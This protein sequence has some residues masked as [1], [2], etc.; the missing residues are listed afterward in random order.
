ML[1][2]R[3]GSH[4][5]WAG[6]NEGGAQAGH[7][8]AMVVRCVWVEPFCLPRCYRA[9][10]E[11]GKRLARKAAQ[12]PFFRDLL[13]PVSGG[14][15]IAPPRPG[16]QSSL[17][18]RPPGLQASRGRHRRRRGAREA[19]QEDEPLAEHGVRRDGAVR[20]LLPGVGCAYIC[21]EVELLLVRLCGRR[22]PRVQHVTDESV[23]APLYKAAL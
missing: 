6:R 13:R 2:H 19:D 14:L 4:S 11:E 10:G 21:L 12:L 5:L 18:A 7:A 23:Q 22:G 9:A 20:G 3:C 8:P 15:Q 1:S 16:E 17:P